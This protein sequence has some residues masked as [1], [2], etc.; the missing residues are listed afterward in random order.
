MYCRNNDSLFTLFLR[1]DIVLMKEGRM[2]GQA[3]I[4]LPSEQSAEKARRE[5]NGYVL[6]DKPLV[7]VSLD[8]TA[9]G[10]TI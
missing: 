1:F 9:C 2:K 8:I 4:G 5:T 6:S 3:F 10:H 7:V